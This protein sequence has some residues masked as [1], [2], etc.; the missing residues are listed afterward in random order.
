MAS[1]SPVV[2]GGRNLASAV[3]E[4]RVR[5]RRFEPFSR[6]FSY[7]IFMFYLDLEEIPEV[8][9]V[10]PLV[11]TRPRSPARFR[12]ADYLGPVDRPLRDA[13]ADLVEERTGSRP[14]GPIRMLTHLR[15]WGVCENPVTFYYCFA[16]DGVELRSVVAEV[17]N[18][19]WGDRHSYLIE[20]GSSSPGVLSTGTP[21]ALHVSPLMSMD[22]HYE[23]R[24]GIPGRTLP[25]HMESRGKGKKAFDAT[26][27]LTRTEI[28]RPVLGRLLRRPPMSLKV[29]SG[30]YLQAGITWARGARYHPRPGPDLPGGDGA[31]MLCP[32]EHRSRPQ[33]ERP[34]AEPVG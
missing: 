5:H 32:V 27:S 9:S 24:F 11:S 17:T 28:S 16:R 33:T 23:L 7:R 8:M 15:Y 2:Q 26:L 30:I 3:Y 21:K 34:S 14:D 13:V 19:P 6:E 20:A 12:R 18:V 22:H 31:A 25:V 29:L 1:K 4:G 10:H